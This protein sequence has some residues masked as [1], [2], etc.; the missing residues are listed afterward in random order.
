[1]S[2]SKKATAIDNALGEFWESIARDYPEATSGDL[3]PDVVIALEQAATSSVEQWLKYNLPPMTIADFDD[4]DEYVDELVQRVSDLPITLF[5]KVET[6]A[7]ERGGSLELSSAPD[8][9]SVY[10]TPLWEATEEELI[11]PADRFI[12]M[13]SQADDGYHF[14]CR[15]P[16]P[17]A[18]RSLD[19]DA[20]LF[21]H[22][23]EERLPS[24]ISESQEAITVQREQL[25]ATATKA[26]FPGP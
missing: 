4:I 10:I 19:E 23:V 26:R 3:P 17:A 11:N 9:C 2:E 15:V 8:N 12:E 13:T 6:L 1:M 20:A 14:S 7:M 21:Q 22:I 24:F 16:Y 25:A 5:N 18:L